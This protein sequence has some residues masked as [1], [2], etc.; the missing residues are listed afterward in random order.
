[1]VTDKLQDIFSKIQLEVFMDF[2]SSKLLQILKDPV[3]NVGC[4]I[5][6]IIIHIQILA[7]IWVFVLRIL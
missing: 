5:I 6:I 3:A 4:D 2:G 1:M 7:H